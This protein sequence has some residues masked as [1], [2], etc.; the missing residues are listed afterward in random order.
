M[1]QPS[2]EGGAGFRWPIHTIKPYETPTCPGPHHR[3]SG[4]RQ[5]CD[6]GSGGGTSGS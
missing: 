4:G 5:H 3:R 1:F 6:A 2:Y